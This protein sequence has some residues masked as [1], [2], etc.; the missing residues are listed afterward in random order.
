MSS[1]WANSKSF[2]LNAGTWAK[3]VTSSVSKPKYVDNNEFLN[4]CVG[5][6]K[7]RGGNLFSIMLH[8]LSIMA[9]VTG[10]SGVYRISPISIGLRKAQAM[11]PPVVLTMSRYMFIQKGA[12]E[13]EIV[14]IFEGNGLSL[15]RPWKDQNQQCLSQ[16]LTAFQHPYSVCSTQS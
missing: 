15:K 11:A 4:L 7:G 13:E 10:V 1:P 16:P 9:L 12:R 8:T 3:R 5:G 2:S 6:V 14:R